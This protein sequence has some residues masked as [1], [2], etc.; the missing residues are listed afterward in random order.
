MS[1]AICGSH[2]H[3][4]ARCTASSSPFGGSGPF[5][6]AEPGNPP[7]D[8]DGRMELPGT[9]EGYEA[10]E[11]EYARDLFAASAMQALLAQMPLGKIPLVAIAKDAY[12]VA[13]AMMAERDKRRNAGG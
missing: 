8:G 1:C 10:G 11:R 6:V 12:N 9:I 7:F 4:T 2:A 13:D 5:S 3:V